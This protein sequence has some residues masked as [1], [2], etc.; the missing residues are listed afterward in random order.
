[1]HLGQREFGMLG[2]FSLNLYAVSLLCTFLHFEHVNFSFVPTW[3]LQKPRPQVEHVK[4]F[5]DK[6]VLQNVQFFADMVGS[7]RYLAP[8]RVSGN[9]TEYET[10]KLRYS[11][12]W[13]RLVRVNL[14]GCI[15]ISMNTRSFPSLVA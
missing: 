11:D 1:L 15:D 8:I 12:R 14:A 6:G 7:G 4:S 3:I 13:Q 5:F 10:I 2:Q 9:I